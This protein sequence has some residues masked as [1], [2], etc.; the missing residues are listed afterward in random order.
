MKRLNVSSAGAVSEL[1]LPFCTESLNPEGLD[2][3]VPSFRPAVDK[4]TKYKQKRYVRYGRDFYSL[5]KT[6]ADLFKY[7]KGD[8]DEAM[9]LVDELIR[10]NIYCIRDCRPVKMGNKIILAKLQNNKVMTKNTGETIYGITI[11]PV[12]TFMDA[13]QNAEVEYHE[14]EE[15][16]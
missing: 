14:T 7:S 13:I 3:V 11:C 8:P 15:E 1:T 5:V 12:G 2:F 6:Y 16:D 9:R 4:F 10:Y